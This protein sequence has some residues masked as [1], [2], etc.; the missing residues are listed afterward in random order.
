MRDLMKQLGTDA[1]RLLRAELALARLELKE[2][3][4]ETAL[5]S[6]R[7]VTALGLVVVGGL[8]LTAMLVLLLGMLLGGAYWA[9]CL[10]V[11]ATMLIAGGFLARNG[12]QGLRQQRIAPEETIQT[13]KENR[14]WARHELR[15]IGQDLRSR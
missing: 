2:T 11:G 5:D 15:E 3:V 8:T 14:D 4:R 13:I 12:L 6:L 7:L 1:N 10:M 9:A